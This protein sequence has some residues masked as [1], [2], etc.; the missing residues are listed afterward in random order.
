MPLPLRMFVLTKAE[1]PGSGNRYV[2]LFS[3]IDNITTC[4]HVKL[5]IL[6]LDG[7]LKSEFWII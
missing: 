4:M 5:H 6:T 1:A 3:S 7:K 2:Q